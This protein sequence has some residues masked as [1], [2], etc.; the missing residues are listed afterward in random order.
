[1]SKNNVNKI[2]DALKSDKAMSEKRKKQPD[3][4]KPETAECAAQQTLK[5]ASGKSSRFTMPEPQTWNGANK[6]S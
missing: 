2:Y 4:A 6:S 1:M 5:S 3:A